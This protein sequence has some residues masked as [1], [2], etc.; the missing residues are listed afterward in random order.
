MNLKMNFY[1]FSWGRVMTMS[2]LPTLLLIALQNSW[3]FL[4]YFLSG[5][6]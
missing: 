3:Y 5:S 4:V 1:P 2:L 6:G